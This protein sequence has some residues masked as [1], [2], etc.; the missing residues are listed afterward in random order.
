MDKAQTIQKFW[1]NFGLPAYDETI[2]PDDA[3]APYITYSVR[4]D[5]LDSQLTLNASVWYRSTS[6]KEVSEKVEEIAQYIDTLYPPAIKLDTGRFY[7]T[8]GVPFAQRV[9]DEDRM[10]RRIYLILNA[11]FLT[12]H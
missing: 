12:E 4:T 1:E 2:V 6:W 3:K 5:S 8:R 11:E 10:V 7:I 9:G